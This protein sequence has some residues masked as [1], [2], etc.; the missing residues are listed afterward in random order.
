M[1]LKNLRILGGGS[2]IQITTKQNGRNLHVY[3]R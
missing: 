3:L 1:F 2:V